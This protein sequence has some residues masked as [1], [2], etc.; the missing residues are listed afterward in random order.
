MALESAGWHVENRIVLL[1]CFKIIQI[2]TIIEI[3]QC[4]VF[5]FVIRYYLYFLKLC[6]VLKENL[7]KLK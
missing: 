3:Y 4:P 1:R 6:N 5:S 2:L 7:Q